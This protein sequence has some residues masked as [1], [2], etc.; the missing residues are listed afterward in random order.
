MSDITTVAGDYSLETT[1]IRFAPGD[2]GNKPVRLSI[3]NDEIVESAE[4]LRLVPSTTDAAV[5]TT[6]ALII[7]LDDDSKCLT[8]K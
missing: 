6:I 8:L 2:V 7:I 5:N 4:S 3:T 1:G